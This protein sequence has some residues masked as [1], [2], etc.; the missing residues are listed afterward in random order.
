MTR[1]D[2]EEKLLTIIRNEKTL[3]PG[4]LDP[5]RPLSEVGVDSL[6]ALNILF[7]IEE[8]F[9][10]SVPDDQARKI[11]TLNDM[12]RTVEQLRAA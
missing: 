3:P 8:T 7:A 6:D 10:I 5:D 1:A 11:R 9:G 4:Q 12:V 2:I